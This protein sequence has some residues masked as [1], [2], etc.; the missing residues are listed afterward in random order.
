M[1]NGLVDDLKATSSLLAP[2]P[3]QSTNHL[4]VNKIVPQG[5]GR[6]CFSAPSRAK[7]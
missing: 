6:S 4:L 7:G 5:E 3:P 2:F 1:A